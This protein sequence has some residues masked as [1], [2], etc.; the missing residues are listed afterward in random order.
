ME[1]TWARHYFGEDDGEMV[2]RTNNA[3]AFL[4]DT[5]DRGPPVQSQTWRSSEK[6]PYGQAHSLRAFEK[7]PL[8]QTQALR[9]FEKDSFHI[10]PDTSAD[11]NGDGRRGGN[12]FTPSFPPPFGSSAAQRPNA[13]AEH[14]RSMWVLGKLEFAVHSPFVVR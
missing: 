9:D 14:P 10:L 6:M 7:P 1:Q 13:S 12:T 8:V 3:A 4:S 2:P 11:N 5:K